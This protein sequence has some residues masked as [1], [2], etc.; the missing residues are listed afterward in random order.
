M[1]RA[2]DRLIMPP[3]T[4]RAIGSIVLAISAISLGCEAPAEAQPAAKAET[5]LGVHDKG[6]WSDLDDDLQLALPHGLSSARVSATIDRDRKLLILSVDGWPTK[7]YPF[8]LRTGDK[9]ELA[10]LLNADNTKDGATPAAHD[11]DRDGIPD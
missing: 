6:I 10:G 4:A 8:P 7:P 5:C 11:R 9:A 1:A 3:T 2:S